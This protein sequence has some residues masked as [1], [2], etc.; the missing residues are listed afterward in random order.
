LDQ[1]SV[2]QLRLFFEVVSLGWAEVTLMS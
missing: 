1:A 2:V